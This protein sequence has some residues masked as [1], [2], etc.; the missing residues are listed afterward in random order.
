MARD[1]ALFGVGAPKVWSIPPGEN[2]LKC[3][4]AELARAVDLQNIPDA[5]ADA[6]I[7][8]PNRRS[9]R[10]LTA[11]LFLAA[12]ETPILSPDIRAM[13]DLESDEAPPVAEFSVTDLPPALAPAKRLGTL[14]SLVQAY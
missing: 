14:A 3:L 8:V 5:L 6:T 10:E 9:A 13:G 2:F 1:P 11:A 12:N 7:Y 4:A